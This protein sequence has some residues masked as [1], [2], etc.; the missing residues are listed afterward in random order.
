MIKIPCLPT[1][2]VQAE[3]GSSQNVLLRMGDKAVLSDVAQPHHACHPSDAT[4]PTLPPSVSSLIFGWQGDE[5]ERA[6]A[7]DNLHE[8]P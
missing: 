4:G 1:H 3:K 8:S 5:G 2:P 6:E 7:A